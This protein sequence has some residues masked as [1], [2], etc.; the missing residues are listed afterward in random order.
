MFIYS[1]LVLEAQEVLVVPANIRKCCI[2]QYVYIK[3]T[4][5]I[6]HQQYTDIKVLK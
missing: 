4:G 6:E 3:H 5:S 2:Q 1:P